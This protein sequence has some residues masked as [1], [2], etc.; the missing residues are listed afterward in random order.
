VPRSKTKYPVVDVFAGPGGLGEGFASFQ[1][2]RGSP[3]FESVASIEIDESSHRTLHL[4]H[5]LRNFPAGEFL[6]NI[7]ST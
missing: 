4:R 1:D 3:M 5:F 6:T 2:E 7:T